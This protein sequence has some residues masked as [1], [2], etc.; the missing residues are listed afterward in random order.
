MDIESLYTLFRAQKVI[1]TDSRHCPPGSI[2]F[3]LRG[4][5]F[6]GNRFAAQALHDGC[7]YAV[8][9]D[10]TVAVDER[11]VLVDDVLQALQALA[12]VIVGSG[13]VR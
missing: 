4:T 8:V 11:Y 13:D 9:D 6:D 12:V 7:A 3:A 1:T 10:S 5:T 2:F